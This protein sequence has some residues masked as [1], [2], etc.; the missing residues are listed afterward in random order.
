MSLK[1]KVLYIDNEAD[2][3]DLAT[4]FFEEENLPIH[5]STNVQDALKMIRENDYD[6]IITDLRMP[7]G[8]GQE[9]LEVIRHECSFRGK[10]I[11]VTGNIGTG[12]MNEQG[13][14]DLVLFKPLRFQDL[15]D[16]VKLLLKL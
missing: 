8:N 10:M 1:P 5:T 7:Q 3:L 13:E 12:E 14:W 9:L 16:Q 4:T 2:L 11:L 6:L 15:I